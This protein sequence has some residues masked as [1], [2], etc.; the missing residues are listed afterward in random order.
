[1]RGSLI[2]GGVLT[3]FAA[4]GIWGFYIHRNHVFPYRSS[5][6]VLKWLR[7]D[8][9]RRFHL[10]KADA[11]RPISPA[12]IERLGQLPYL[13]GYRPPSGATSV[14]R[15]DP[16]RADEGWNLF[17]SGHAPAA[18]L[19]DMDGKVLHTWTADVTK[20]FPNLVVRSAD[21]RESTRFLRD[22]HLLPGGDIIVMMQD[23]GVVRLDLDS[24]VR[25][26]WEAPVHHELF[27]EPSGGV[28][29]LTHALTKTSDLHSDEPIWDDYV[30]QLSPQGQPVRKISIL[31]SLR[32][33]SYAP[34]LTRLAHEE[35]VFHT[36]SLQVLD[37]TAADRSPL[38]RKGNLLLSIRNLE[39][40]AILDPD[41]RRLVWALTGQWHQQHCG[42]LLPNGH[43][44]LFDNLGSLH[45]ASR[46]LE[47]DPWTQQ[48]VW[49]YGG[50][51]GQDFFSETNGFLRRLS[52]GNTIV[53]ETNVGRVLEVTPEGDVV[54]EFVSPYHAGEKGKYVANIFALERVP[55]DILAPSA[56]HPGG[57][58]AR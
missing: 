21:R 2:C 5:H 22:A 15:H 46:I 24:R 23:I 17:V 4:A 58:P 48:V 55:R 32:R 7:A 27:V 28:W 30:V 41:A 18:T 49:S 31:E 6:E 26:S 12:E 43:L 33:S 50:V 34:L 51:P 36:N 16:A 35:D 40:L 3:L 56:G 10:V 37:G 38:W 54:W 44:L 19:M 45:A 57:V 53:G 11:R 47:V 52:N 25:W 1:V 13:R 20:A 39:L 29:A 9:P 14:L 42:R 8:A